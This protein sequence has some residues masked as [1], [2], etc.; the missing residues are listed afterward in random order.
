MQNAAVQTAITQQESLFVSFWPEE[1]S[2]G[3]LFDWTE[4]QKCC[5]VALV[6]LATLFG[7]STFGIVGAIV[8][9]FTTAVSTVVVNNNGCPSGDPSS[10]PRPRTTIPRTPTLAPRVV[11]HVPHVPPAQI[12][13]RHTSIH[14]VSSHVGRPV[15]MGSDQRSTRSSTRH[16]PLQHATTPVSMGSGQRSTRPSTA[17]R[18]STRS[19]NMGSS[20]SGRRSDVRRSQSAR[21]LPRPVQLGSDN[22]RR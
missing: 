8:S 18:T 10:V 11:T 19:V 9:A 14:P 7:L 21:T 12:S 1:G 4:A 2:C 15:S 6:I 17:P 13:T 20:R 16:M 3:G 22:R 5:A